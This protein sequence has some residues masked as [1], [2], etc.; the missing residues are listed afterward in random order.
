MASV[1][2]ETHEAYLLHDAGARHPESPDRLRAVREGAAAAGLGNEL[3]VVTPRRATRAELTAVHRADVLDA[4]EEFCREGGG[5]VEPPNT[6]VGADS[7][8]AAV[9]AAGAGLDAVER[10]R[11]GEA[12]AAFCAVRPPGHHATPRSPMGFCVLNNVAVTAA[13]LAAAGERVAIVDYD[14]HHGNG[15]QDAFWSDP[16]VL[17]VS[18][19]EFGPYVYPSGSGRLDQVGDGDG[20]GF[21]VNVPFSSGTGGD[22]YRAAFDRVVEPVVAAFGADWLLVSAGFD[23]HLADPLTDLGLTAGAFGELTA[24]LVRLAPPGRVVAFLEGGYDFA[25]LSASTAACVRALGGAEGSD[26][27][28]GE[29]R[30]LGLDVVD[31]VARLHRVDSS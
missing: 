3:V 24:R 6:H 26:G 9:L 7:W 2:F 11:R 4:V 30:G 31:A 18:L 10:L 13:A 25:A 12:S 1:L 28:L 22:A 27:R 5:W 23:A 19:H 15:T 17:Y 14:A 20:A 21:T 29:G 8:D 16:R